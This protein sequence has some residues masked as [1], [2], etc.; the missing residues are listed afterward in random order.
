[1]TWTDPDEMDVTGEIGGATFVLV[2]DN[3]KH[4]WDEAPR[5]TVRLTSTQSVATASDHVIQW[6]EAAWDSTS[7]DMWDAGTPGSLVVPTG[8]GGLY[9]GV[10][11]HHWDGTTD[12]NSK[13]SA[14]VVKNGGAAD[15]DD[16]GGDDRLSTSSPRGTFTIASSF[17]AGDYIEVIARQLSG[18][19]LNLEPYRTRFT[20]FLIGADPSL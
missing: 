17:A 9:L 3:L 10:G 2:R 4:I 16:L 15:S 20:F 12:D 8:G 14:K 1:M 11:G 5:L 7:G 6:D 13:R 18:A 19:A